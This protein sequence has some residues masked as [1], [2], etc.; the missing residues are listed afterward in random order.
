M[1]KSG[2]SMYSERGEKYTSIKKIKLE[3]P[4]TEFEI[5]NYNTKNVGKLINWNR[6]AYIFL[7]SRTVI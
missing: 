7:F 2:A 4:R 6:P 5:Y 3:P 1:R